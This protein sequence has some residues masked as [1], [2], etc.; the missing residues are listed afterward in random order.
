MDRDIPEVGITGIVGCSIV[1]RVY[2]SDAAKCIG[3]GGVVLRGVPLT[4]VIEIDTGLGIPGG[5]IEGNGIPPR[6]RPY[7]YPIA[8][9][10]LYGIPG[11]RIVIAIVQCDSFLL[12]PA[13]GISLDL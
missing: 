8:V 5:I 13:R 6:S 9:I 1:I 4:V 10:A 12:T 2:E 11:D 3:G 7:V